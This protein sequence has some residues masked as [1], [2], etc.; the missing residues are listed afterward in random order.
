MPRRD[1]SKR[2]DLCCAAGFRESQH[3]HLGPLDAAAFFFGAASLNQP[4][5]FQIIPVWNS[6][7]TPQWTS[8]RRMCPSKPVIPA[9]RAE[10]VVGNGTAVHKPS[11]KSRS[12]VPA[13]GGVPLRH[14]GTGQHWGLARAKRRRYRDPCLKRVGCTS[15]AAIRYHGTQHETRHRQSQQ[16]GP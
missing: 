1:Q 4:R 6:R 16:V 2:R 5:E 15:I 14:T 13:G 10:T 7:Q 8:E 11:R 3:T 12:L 9:P